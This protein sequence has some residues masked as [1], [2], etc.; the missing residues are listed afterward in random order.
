[1]TKVGRLFEIEK[2]E[3]VKKAVLEM[4]KQLA[5]EKRKA[6]NKIRTA[7]T[8]ARTAETKAENAETKARTAELKVCI[9]QMLL[10]GNTI[11]D[12]AQKLHM[13]PSDVAELIGEQTAD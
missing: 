8:K 5:L 11:S 3:A 2:E 10:K 12:A 7:E 6:E 13:K 1:M 9:L 4:Q